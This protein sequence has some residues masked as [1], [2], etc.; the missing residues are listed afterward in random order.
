MYGKWM[1]NGWDCLSRVNVW[2]SGRLWDFLLKTDAADIKKRANQNRRNH[3]SR[4]EKTLPNINP[5]YQK[6][7]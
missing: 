4:K 6:Y 5:I 7:N 3:L 1:K 2:S